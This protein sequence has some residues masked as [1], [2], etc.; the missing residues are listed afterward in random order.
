MPFSKVIVC[1]DRG[2][3]AQMHLGGKLSI[4]GAGFN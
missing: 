1:L 4:S 2:W 3:P